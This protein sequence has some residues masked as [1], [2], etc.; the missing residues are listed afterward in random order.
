MLV[1]FF[2]ESV[3]GFALLGLPWA[4]LCYNYFILFYFSDFSSIFLGFFFFFLKVEQI[5]FFFFKFEGVP[6]F[7]IKG[8]PNSA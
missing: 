4:W 6:N 1:F 8:V 2:L 5:I 3:G 7:V